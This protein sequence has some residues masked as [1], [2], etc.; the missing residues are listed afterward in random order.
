MRQT[1]YLT[2]MFAAALLGSGVANAA[3]TLYASDYTGGS[4]T[5]GSAYTYDKLVVDTPLTLGNYLDLYNG[6]TLAFSKENGADAIC[7]I[8]TAE[9]RGASPT[10]FFNNTGD[11][12]NFTFDAGA[13]AIVAASAGTPITLIS[14]LNEDCGGFSF[15]YGGSPSMTT[16][17]LNGVGYNQTVEMGGVQFTYVGPQE[18]T[19]T[20]QEGEIGFTGY[21]QGSH[22][23]K[24]VANGKPTPEPTTGTLSLLALAGLCAR[25]RK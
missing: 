24:L 6:A 10:V 7:S 13:Q 15:Y 21:Y 17:T 1:L 8:F 19:Y 11:V 25:R 18:D 9:S 5:L 16:L 4:I 23:L 12:Y 3:E 20:F 22:A 14:D 2:T